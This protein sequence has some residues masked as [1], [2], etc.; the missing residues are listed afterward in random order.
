MSIKNRDKPKEI[1]PKEIEGIPV[2]V[3]EGVAVYFVVPHSEVLN[4]KPR[5]WPILH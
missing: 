3:L 2:D 4:A 5:Y 1:L